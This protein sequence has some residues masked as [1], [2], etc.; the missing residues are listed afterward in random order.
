MRA[1][2]AKTRTNSEFNECNILKTN[3]CT[4]SKFIVYTIDV[5]TFYDRHQFQGE[6]KKRNYK[7]KLLTRS[8]G[9]QILRQTEVAKETLSMEQRECYLTQ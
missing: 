4:F 5:L 6:D 9:R 7:F 3:F 1:S 8:N 2:F